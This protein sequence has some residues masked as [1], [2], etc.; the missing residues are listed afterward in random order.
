MSLSDDRFRYP[1]ADERYPGIV[2]VDD[3]NWMQRIGLSAVPY[4]IWQL[5]YWKVSLSV[6]LSPAHTQ[7]ISVDRHEKI[8]SGQREN[9]FH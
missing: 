8:A 1:N 5:T 6:P 2:H 4:C 9:S 7:F 3:Y